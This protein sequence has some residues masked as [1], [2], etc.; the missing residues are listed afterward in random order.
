[1]HLTFRPAMAAVFRQKHAVACLQKIKN[2]FIVF[3][4]K[5]AK[6]MRN[7]DTAFCFFLHIRH[8]KNLCPVKTCKTAAAAVLTQI[9]LHHLFHI[10]TISC[11]RQVINLCL[12]ILSLCHFFKTYFHLNLKTNTFYPHTLRASLGS[13]VMIASAPYSQSI[14]IYDSSLTVQT[15][16]FFCLLRQSSKNPGYCT[17]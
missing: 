7:H 9:W 13:F 5:F 11:L 16:T 6:S 1:M 3:F 2:H 14:C 8:K 4:C 15:C 17:L 12:F 10:F